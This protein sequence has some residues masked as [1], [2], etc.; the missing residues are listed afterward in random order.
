MKRPFPL[1]TGI[2]VVLLVLVGD[3]RS[4]EPAQAAFSI[5]PFSAEVTIPLGHRCMGIL[6]KKADHIDD[7]LEAHG[8]VLLGP[9]KPIVLLALD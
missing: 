2:A 3:G 4:A 1:L 6:P 7:P 5:A 8:F 9:D